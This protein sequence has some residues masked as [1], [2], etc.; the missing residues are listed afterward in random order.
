MGGK[1]C[2]VSLS[3]RDHAT[4]AGIAKWLSEI[5]VNDAAVPRAGIKTALQFF[6]GKMPTLKPE[7]AADFLRAM[8]LSRPVRALTLAVNE[9]VIAFRKPNE[10]PI[11]LFYTRSGSSKFNSGI[12]PADR[13][14]VHFRVRVPCPALESYTTGAIDVW[15]CP[16]SMTVAPR[17][18]STGFMA[19]GGGIQ[20]IIPDARR[21][22]EMVS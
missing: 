10:D 8:D 13:A 2:V 1:R 15:S 17:A 14:A 19:M 21:C 4:P 3:L 22:L 7:L 20:L 16:S 11:K 12:N 18:N 6:A 9:R 5:S